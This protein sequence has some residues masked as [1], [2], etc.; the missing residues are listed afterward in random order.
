MSDHYA[1]KS[2]VPKLPLER[3]RPLEE[4]LS[5]RL[6]ADPEALARAAKAATQGE[7]VA[8]EIEQ[9]RDAALRRAKHQSRQKAI[10]EARAA[11]RAA[12]ASD[13]PWKEKP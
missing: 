4:R 11:G 9:S 7:R 1:G 6:S 12:P 5:V 13:H 2:F 10:A 3:L 8:R